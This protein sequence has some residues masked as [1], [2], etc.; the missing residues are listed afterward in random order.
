[1]KKN[2]IAVILTAVT[3]VLGCIIAVMTYYF[4]DAP[5][6]AG[7]IIDNHAH[8]FPGK[9][10]Q[11][12]YMDK[13]ISAMDRA[14]VAK[15]VLGL[16]AKHGSFGS[17]FDSIHD[18][19]VREASGRY[20]ERIYPALGGFDPRLESSV[21]Y[22]KG[23]L[24]TGFWKAI[25]ELDLRNIAK[26]Q[27][28]PADSP[29]MMKIYSLAARHHVPVSIHYNYDY[30]TDF[31]SGVQEFERAVA[32][33]PDTIF[34]TAHQINARLMEKHPNLWGEYEYRPWNPPLRESVGKNNSLLNR[35]V[36]GTDIQE[37]D[38]VCLQRKRPGEKRV[39]IPYEE[40]I[41]RTRKEL[42]KLPPE[43]AEK[44]AYKNLQD[45]IKG[46]QGSGR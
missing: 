42:G 16:N 39:P 1:M 32:G 17:A 8:V 14:G 12:A 46:N 10:G 27:Q 38:L 45:L 29:V 43:L 6:Y 25:G 31:Q 24:E 30:G 34:I 26:H 22:V 44:A 9:G 3:A 28:I 4:Y 41:R 36:V 18:A 37:P 19:W 21:E 35:I 20:P 23:Q 7:P 15:I 2:R 40:L 33:N 13:L 5:S 11:R